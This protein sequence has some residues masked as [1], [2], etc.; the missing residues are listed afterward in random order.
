MKKLFI[1]MMCLAA[2]AFTSCKPDPEPEPEPEPE[3][4]EEPTESFIGNYEGTIYLNAIATS[5]QWEGVSQNF[6]SVAFH[7]SAAIT[8]GDN[9]ESIHA[10]FTI[11]GNNDEE[12]SCQTTGTVNGKH[13]DFGDITIHYVENVNDLL[14]TLTLSGDL[15][16]NILTLNGPATG[17]GN[18]IFGGEPT[19]IELNVTGTVVGT[20]TKIHHVE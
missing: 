9:D 1:L 12:E 6:D 8:A 18:V 19:P 13:A 2:V 3:P 4:I 16:N 5:P 14:V 20:L 15:D 17:S 7:L 10:L 11:P